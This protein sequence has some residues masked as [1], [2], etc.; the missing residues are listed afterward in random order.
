MIRIMDII[1]TEQSVRVENLAISLDVSENTIRRDLNLLAEK[2]QL[3]RTKGGAVSLSG[4]SPDNTFKDRIDKN[5]NSK[6][7][8][9]EKAASFINRGETLILDGGTTNIKLAEKIKK[10]EHVTVLTNSL[11]IANI[12]LGAKGITL[13]IC[14]GIVNEDSRTMTGI[15]AERFFSDINADKLF[16][17]VTALSALK[18][19]SDQ[20]MYETPVKKKMISCAREIIVLADSTKFNKT[21]FSPIGDLSLAN[22]IIT[23]KEPDSQSRQA[24]EAKGVKLIACS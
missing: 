12:L 3:Q 7:I 24:I 8:I 20:N 14:G 5:C 1:K 9:A 13:V 21:A 2:H 6:G 10:M 11:D 15:P 23:D 17:A 19:L 16:L 18:G 4:T 22:I